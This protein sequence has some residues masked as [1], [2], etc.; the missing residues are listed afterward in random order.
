MSPSFG[1]LYCSLAAAGEASGALDTILQ[2]Q[3]HYLKTLQE[4]QGRVTLALIYPAFLMFSGI[5]VSVI[6]VTKLIPQLTTLLETTPGAKMPLG[7]VI[8]IA[9]SGLHHEVVGWSFCSSSSP[10]AGVLFKAWKDAEANKPAWDRIKLKAAACMG[11][12]GAALLRAVP[13]DDGEPGGQRSALSC[14]R[15]S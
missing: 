7:A 9:I 11:G 10:L 2:R 3:A 12:G 6:F 8:L 14:A 13:R 4:L 5:M 1:P 15:S